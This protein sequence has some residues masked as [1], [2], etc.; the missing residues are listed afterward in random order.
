MMQIGRK[1]VLT[2]IF[3][4][5][6]L[7]A[8]LPA[9]AASE[10]R[11]TIVDN[12]G[13][14]LIGASIRIDGTN[15]GVTADIDG[16]FTLTPTDGAKSITIT[17][18]GMK[19]QT[20]QLDKVPAK[21]IM[22]EDSTLLQE[23]VVSACDKNS[24]NQLHA[25]TGIVSRTTKKCI[26]TKCIDAYE[27]G[28]EEYLKD[29]D[30]EFELDDNGQKILVN[31]E[32]INTNGRDCSPMPA[33]AKIAKLE[34]G[35]CVIKKCN[36][37][38]YKLENGTCVDQIGK[39]CTSQISHAITASYQLDGN[40]LKCIVDKCDEPGW[41]PNASKTKC[42]ASDG[43][44]TSDQI[45]AVAH[46]KSGSLRKGECIITECESG[47]HVSKDGKKCEQA[48]LSEADSKAKVDELRDN[49]QK[50]KDKE[51]STANKM[52]G[53]AAIGATG[54]GAMNLMSG[55][56]EQKADDSAEED[57]KAYLAT[58]V[59]DYGQGRNIKGGEM[60]IDLPGGNELF[61]QVNEYRTLA[62]DLKV[63]KEA[64][65][66]TPGIESEIIYDAAETGL[67]DNVG[68]GRQSG[69]Y[70]SLSR[71]LT[72][73]NSADAEAWAKQKADTA[74]KVKTGA[75][76]AGAGAVGGLIGNLAINSGEKNKN[77]SDKIINE[78]AKKKQ[79]IREELAPI[80]QQSKQEAI[81]AP[82]NIEDDKEEN[83]PPIERKPLAKLDISPATI[84]NLAP[85]TLDPTSIKPI[86]NLTQPQNLH[87]PLFTLYNQSL[88]DSGKYELK[89][90]AHNKLDDVIAK[91]TTQIGADV[92]YEIIL[93]AHTDR[94]KIRTNSKLYREGVTT[95]EQL[96]Q[97]RGD[98]VKDYLVKNSN[99]KIP[100]VQVR[101]VSKGDTCATGTTAKDK[102]L[103]RK[104]D[105]Y[106]LFDGEELD[107]NHDYCNTQAEN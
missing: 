13:E 68:M 2:S 58:F 94:D 101:I 23:V 95:N 88:F 60:N 20:F 67:Y 18:L 50:M 75:I 16:N 14:G 85:K 46:A 36:E 1:S 84:P 34:N 100:D 103:D 32:C 38:Q 55:L 27:L 69:A 65:G 87:K 81:E 77:Q 29:E 80:E 104:V 76:T 86:I 53:G 43:P 19:P 47:W 45:S 17:Y 83:T 30:G 41:V 4:L 11:S 28:S 57:M 63:R 70:T 99:G 62:A 64:L 39:D 49:A 90:T 52:L 106:L 89:T 37:P 107:S 6:A 74:S 61:D 8:I 98:A 25:A 91:L 93:A 82:A 24:L 54:I 7:F 97:K 56:S 71:A 42:E 33:N 21:I 48:E 40:A 5:T 102:A 92:N 78:Y 44:C 73:E 9:M 79:Q 22:Q 66:K 35:K 26:P 72:D 105:F 3:A 96:A 59:C 31:S 15:Q 12:T 51:Q 10:I